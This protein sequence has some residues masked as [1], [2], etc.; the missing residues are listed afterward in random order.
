[1]KRRTERIELRLTPEEAE[2]IK[3]KSKSYQ[4]VSQYVRLAVKEFSDID[5]RKKLDMI[6]DLTD[7][8]VRFRD[9]LAWAGSNLNQAMKHAN[10][11]AK[12]GLLNGEY[13]KNTVLPAVI[14]TEKTVS[15]AKQQL[16][17][18]AKKATKLS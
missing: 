7:L 18:L 5:A 6:K 3:E 9:E 10:E 1:M 12:V 15:A 4:S 17:D 16:I 13:M 8:C 14:Q 2:Y 11:L